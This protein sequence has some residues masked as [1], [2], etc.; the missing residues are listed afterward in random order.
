MQSEIFSL[1]LWLISQLGI[2]QM[3]YKH[4]SAKT[5]RKFRFLVKESSNVSFQINNYV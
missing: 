5:E 3:N 4:N 1:S 2:F